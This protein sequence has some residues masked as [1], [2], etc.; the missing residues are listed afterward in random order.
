M[1]NFLIKLDSNI[2]VVKQA[3]LKGSNIMTGLVLIP[4]FVA[5]FMVHAQ[6]SKCECRKYSTNEKLCN[7]T[8]RLIIL[9]F[10]TLANT[11]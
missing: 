1:G 6:I 11:R 3:M 8:C 9:Y 4:V 7:M 10:T 2:V 5:L